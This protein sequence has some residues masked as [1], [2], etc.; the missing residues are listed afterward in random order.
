M[1][2]LIG[3]LVIVALIAVIA[4]PRV[5]EMQN[6]TGAAEDN[7]NVVTVGGQQVIQGDLSNVVELIGSTAA[8][9]S[10]SVLPAMPAEVEEIKVVA[11]EYVNEGDVLFVL[12]K[13]SV[14]NQVTQ[15]EIGL[16]MAEVGVSNA[17]AGITQAQLGYTQAKSNYEMQLDQ[18]E[19]SVA[20]LEKYEALYA[21]GYA[22]EMELEQMRLQASPETVTLLEKQLEMSAASLNTASLGLESAEASL[23]QA[24]E[25]YDSAID[26]LDDM[27]VTA[28]ISGFV[29]Q[30]FITEGNFASNAQPAMMIEDISEIIVSA[31]VTESLINDVQLGQKVTV[32][33]GSLNN[34]EFEGVVDQVSVSADARTLLY[35]IKVRV[36]N[37]DNDIKPGMFATVL[38]TTETSAEAIYVPSE[39]VILRDGVKYAYLLEGED[40]VKRVEVVTGI[41][42]GYFTEIVEG[43][44]AEDIIITNGIGLIDEKSTIKLIR[45]DQ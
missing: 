16:T 25:G 2:K 13:E 33:V 19:F 18:Y 39:A 35:P 44:V 5:M 40:K 34:M 38:L 14:E 29:S 37:S 15:A 31:S 36:T 12:D 26:L 22:S 42:T 1:K 20:N 17:K 10:V 43:V 41:D 11:G 3:A 27:T 4:V 9:E 45:S 8:N 7:I 24:Q 21:D 6:N 23:L 28:S 30:N 32:V